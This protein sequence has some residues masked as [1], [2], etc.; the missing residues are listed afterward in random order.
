MCGSGNL[1]SDMAQTN[2]TPQSF[3]NLLEAQTESAR[4]WFQPAAR[5]PARVCVII[6]F[7]QVD[8]IGAS[9]NDLAS[10]A[11]LQRMFAIAMQ[12]ASKKHNISNSNCHPI[13]VGLI[14]EPKMYTWIDVY[15]RAHPQPADIMIPT[16]KTRVKRDNRDLTTSRAWP[17]YKSGIA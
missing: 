2:I 14:I 3:Q 8:V 7:A 6:I 4:L 15:L 1:R 9:C 10:L 16:R 11:S 5:N 13:Q 12:V 17:D